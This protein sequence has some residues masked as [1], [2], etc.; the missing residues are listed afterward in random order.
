MILFLS[1]KTVT[2]NLVFLRRYKI[3]WF[4]L[5]LGI[6]FTFFASKYEKMVKKVIKRVC[7]E[8][9]IYAIHYQFHTNFFHIWHWRTYIVY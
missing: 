7:Q 4:R 5:C 9:A 6:E 1:E 8:I 3:I 2:Q